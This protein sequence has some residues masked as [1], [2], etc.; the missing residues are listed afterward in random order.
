MKGLLPA[1]PFVTLD[2]EG[3]GEL[4]KIA[5]ERGRATRPDIKLGICGEHG[6]DP[7][8]IAFC[9]EAQL[10]YV[11]CSP[12]RVPIARLAAAQAALGRKAPR[13]HE[14]VSR[15]ELESRRAWVGTDSAVGRIERFEAPHVV[16]IEPEVERPDVLFQ[17]LGRTVFGMA[18]RPLSRCQR[19]TT[20]AGVFR[21]F[22]A[23]PAIVAS[24]S[25]A[26][27]AERAPGFRFDPALV[28]KRSQRLLLEP[29]M[30]LDLVDGGRDPGLG[31]D[32]LEVIAIE[33]RDPDRADALR[34]FAAG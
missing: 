11:S 7:A 3:V 33:I 2:S 32:P 28:V 9:E 23:M 21:C 16:V 12:F 29:R 18:I 17:S 14:A 19:I 15:R 10:D 4:V 5:V 31:D 1:D 6:G 30:K 26:A 24:L 8:S 22:A 27:A 34:P 25:E 20:C 13:P